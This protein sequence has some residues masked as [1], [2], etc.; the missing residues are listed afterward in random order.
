MIILVPLVPDEPLDEPFDADLTITVL[1]CP[2]TVT[3][4][5]AVPSVD[6]PEGAEEPVGRVVSLKS[7]M[8]FSFSLYQLITFSA[9]SPVV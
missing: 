3:E 9:E 1:V 8:P 2:L 5:M 4:N 6:C 7:V